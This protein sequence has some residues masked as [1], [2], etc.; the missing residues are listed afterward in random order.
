MEVCKE[1]L[2]ILLRAMKSIVQ[3]KNCPEWVSAKLNKAV[4]EA[5]EYK[6]EHNVHEEMMEYVPIEI[7]CLCQ[8]NV[9]ND[10]CTYKV[11]EETDP[12]AGVRLFNIQIMKGNKQNPPGT[13]IHNVAIDK[14]IGVK[15]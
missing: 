8:S 1:Q 10:P 3:T 5:K 14:L 9:P 2:N 11:L 6:V 4:K 7:G 15:E 12:V 13:I